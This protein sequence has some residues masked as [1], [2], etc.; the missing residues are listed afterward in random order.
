MSVRFFFSVFLFV[1]LICW[2]VSSGLLI[3]DRA[4]RGGGRNKRAP[5]LAS[6]ASKMARGDLRLPFRIEFTVFFGCGCRFISYFTL[7]SIPPA[8]ILEP[9]WV[10]LGV[11][12]GHLGPILCHL[13]TILGPTWTHLGPIMGHLVAILGTSWAILGPSWGHLGAF[14]GY[15]RT[16]T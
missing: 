16:R 11:S 2:D 9:S 10:H 15:E 13:G 1:G 6:I 3:F 7:F 12:W 5:H 14:Q 8:H 4:P